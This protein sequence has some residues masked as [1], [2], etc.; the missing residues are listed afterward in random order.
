MAETMLEKKKAFHFFHSK[1]AK[2]DGQPGLDQARA[3][4]K[5]P[6]LP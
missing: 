6:L 1:F 5:L 2:L 3:Y 4:A